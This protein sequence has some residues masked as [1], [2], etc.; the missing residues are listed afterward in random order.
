[1]LGCGPLASQF[2]QAWVARAPSP[3]AFDVNDF[4]QGDVPRGAPDPR[5]LI[6]CYSRAPEI[7]EIN[8][9]AATQQLVPVGFSLAAV[10]CWGTSDFSGGYASKR[11]DAFLV[12]MLSH[13]S[14]FVLMLALALLTHASYPSPSSR[15]WALIAGAFGGTALAIFYRTLGSAD[16]GITAPVAAVLGAAIPAVFAMITQGLPGIQA[17]AGFVLAG[18][19]IWLISRP[20]G[21]VRNY[22]GISMAALAGIGFAGFF[23]CINRTGESSVLW[24]AVHSRVASLGIVGAIV[25]F[26]R[27]RGRLHPSGATLALFAGC[28]DVTGTALF[29]RAEQTGRLD[30]AVVLSSLYPV[31]TVLLARMVLHENFTRWKTVGIFAALLAVPLIALQ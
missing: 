19:G 9:L 24:S 12:T 26:R 8:C 23:I 22:A 4:R 14:G 2:R 16:M 13:A 1:M 30:S 10:L 15:N 31:I 7:E 21:S 5:Y 25:L 17:I 6:A 3:A 20:D 29:I 27:G 28:L 11:S 18:L